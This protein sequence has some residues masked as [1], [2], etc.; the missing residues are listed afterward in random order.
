M[1][2]QTAWMVDPLKLNVSIAEVVAAAAEICQ[3]A[4]GERWAA[5]TFVNRLA[6]ALMLRAGEPTTTMKPPGFEDI[7]KRAHEIQI[8]M[9]QPGVVATADDV[10]EHLG[11]ADLLQECVVR[12][13]L[14]AG[15]VMQRGLVEH[16]EGHA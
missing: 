3:K 1:G 13:A 6:L 14:Q 15:L 8:T 11:T 9:C 2:E 12:I 4:R 7:M 5:L 16:P 10:N